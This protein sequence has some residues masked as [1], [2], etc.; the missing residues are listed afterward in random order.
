LMGPVALACSKHR[1]QTALQLVVAAKESRQQLKFQLLL[2]HLVERYGLNTYQDH[3]DF[4]AVLWELETLRK[5]HMPQDSYSPLFHLSCCFKAKALCSWLVENKGEEAIRG[6]DARGNNALMAMLEE[7]EKV[8]DKRSLH[9]YPISKLFLQ[10]LNWT[11]FDLK[12]ANLAGETIDSIANRIG[13]AWLCEAIQKK[14]TL[15]L[16][17]TM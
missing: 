12:H 2:T 10:L 3:D 14:L 6:L 11:C 4:F 17:K 16:K 1:Y 9:V 15:N 8:R 7:L 5:Q 13:E